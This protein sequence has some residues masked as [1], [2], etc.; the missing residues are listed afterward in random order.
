MV[1]QLRK[2][3]LGLD[4]LRRELSRITR[5]FHRRTDLLQQAVEALKVKAGNEY[6]ELIHT[7][8][9]EVESGY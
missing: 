1:T 8:E 4:S 7:L 9:A 3:K 2:S 6:K 5:A